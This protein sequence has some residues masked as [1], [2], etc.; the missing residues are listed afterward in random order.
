MRIKQEIVWEKQETAQ[1]EQEIKLLKEWLPRISME[2]RAYIKGATK[3]LL[4]AQED[5][6]KMAA[7]AA[8]KGVLP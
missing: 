8:Q 6:Q 4:Y 1:E 5:N 3:A 2:F 7:S